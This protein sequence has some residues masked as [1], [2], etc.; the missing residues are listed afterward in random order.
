MHFVMGC[1]MAKVAAVGSGGNVMTAKGGPWDKKHIFCRLVT[2]QFTLPIKIG[3]FRGRYKAV[4]PH[5]L[6]WKNV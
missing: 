2:K 5:T 3:T 1:G 4:G 6:E